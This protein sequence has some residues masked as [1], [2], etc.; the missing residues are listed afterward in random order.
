MDKKRVMDK[1]QRLRLVHKDTHRPGQDALHHTAMPHMKSLDACRTYSTSGC[2]LISATCSVVSTAAQPMNMLLKTCRSCER[3]TR[4]N[5]PS[6]TCTEQPD[7]SDSFWPSGRNSWMAHLG[8][9]AAAL[10]LATG[11]RTNHVGP[12]RP[13]TGVP[14]LLPLLRHPRATRPVQPERV[15]WPGAE[16]RH[17]LF[18]FVRRPPRRRAALRNARR[19][20][21]RA[22]RAGEGVNQEQ[23]NV[24]AT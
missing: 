7:P 23:L 13:A 19:R 6:T 5:T 1:K 9:L 2:A 18:G 17:V 4:Q 8:K 14:T 15:V 16:L 3:S 10:V 22:G 11:L 21:A 24:L 12:A 20:Q